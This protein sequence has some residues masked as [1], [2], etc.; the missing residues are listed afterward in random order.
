M[1]AD[2]APGRPGP[3]ERLGD[4]LLRQLPITDAGEHGAQ[5]G[6]RLAW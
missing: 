3:G 1:P 6:I 2:F 5:A 4:Q